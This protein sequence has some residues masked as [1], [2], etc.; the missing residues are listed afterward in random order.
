[1]SEQPTG[2]D[3]KEF[4]RDVVLEVI[5]GVNEAA[6]I[7]REAHS[8]EALRGAVNP[9]S[10]AATRDIE[11]DVAITVSRKTGAELGVRVP[12]LSAG[13]G[14][15]RGEQR[16]SRVK[17]SVP[18]AFASQPVGSEYT[19]VGAPGPASAYGDSSVGQRGPTGPPVSR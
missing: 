2:M 8:A 3:L 4:V 18:V 9:Q 6:D 17:F 5:R 10:K 16:T 7:V 13:G 12:V 1:M 15:D 19:D 14:I 11:F